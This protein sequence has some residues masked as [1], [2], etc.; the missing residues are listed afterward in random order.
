MSVILVNMDDLYPKNNNKNKKLFCLD[1]DIIFED[2]FK[3]KSPGKLY[4][5]DKL[6]GKYILIEYIFLDSGEIL[7]K[8]IT[9]VSNI[10][11]KNYGNT[12]YSFN[13]IYDLL[14]K[15]EEINGSSCHLELLKKN[16]IQH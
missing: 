1:F 6:H 10:L 9:N 2:G 11:K 14:E 15:Y 8:F 16:Y 5:R 7:Y 3:I 13:I 12:Y 4:F